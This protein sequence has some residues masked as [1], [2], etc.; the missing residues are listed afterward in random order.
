[1]ASDPFDSV[2]SIVSS[3]PFESVSIKATEKFGDWRDTVKPI[4]FGGKQTVVRPQDDAIWNQD[5]KRWESVTG[6]KMPDAPQSSPS[7]TA[8][9]INKANDY[10]G[11]ALLG[12][13]KAYNAMLGPIIKGGARL[14]GAGGIANGQED[15]EKSINDELALRAA[16]N[17]IG[18]T[19]A[20]IGGQAIPQS[21]MIAAIPGSGVLNNM[22]AG[23][24]T[25]AATTEGD[26][27]DRLS[28]AGI[29]AAGSGLLSG[30][31]KLV[32]SGAN[33]VVN[34][35]DKAKRI[36]NAT[37]AVV[38][39]GDVSSSPILQSIEQKLEWIPGTGMTAVRKKGAEAL[40][41]KVEGIRASAE[42][43]VGTK[44]QAGEFFDS[45]SRGLSERARALGK[46][47]EEIGQIV[48]SVPGSAGVDNAIKSVEVAA[49][50][51]QLPKTNRATISAL[52]DVLSD[53]DTIKQRGVT[54]GG[55]QSLKTEVGKAASEASAKGDTSKASALWDVYGGLK[56]DARASISKADASGKLSKYFDDSN[57]AW[58]KEFVPYSRSQKA[59]AESTKKYAELLVAP[60]KFQQTELDS[61]LKMKSSDVP[62]YINDVIDQPGRDALKSAILD[63]ISGVSSQGR[64][65]IS[66]AKLRNA[67]KSKEAWINSLF[68]KE[69]QAQ[70]K[71]LANASE[72]MDRFGQYMERLGTGKEIEKMSWVKSAI[73]GLASVGAGQ[74]TGA[75]VVAI[76][77]TTV[78]LG[79]AYTALTATRAGQDFLRKAAIAVPGSKFM[80][81]IITKELPVALASIQG[82]KSPESDGA[83]DREK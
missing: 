57:S 54:F 49:S 11:D 78:G 34:L 20:S 24:L 5:S 23:A 56:D 71:G 72:H 77:G 67:I 65:P 47:F 9:I 76:H 12:T 1:M 75:P 69:E 55:I 45:A 25:A 50:R 14:V 33:K 70:M 30:G 38:P 64:T 40:S 26:A 82:Q 48:D 21:L 43:I 79:R 46:P 16:E 59:G 19:I 39:L 35:I 60:Q 17:P 6:K 4:S 83:I 36:Y 51:V 28:S 15:Y 8:K 22:K 61:L 7:T 62:K 10:A 68:S 31:A 41:S 27:G 18:S 81:S 3:D 13:G 53:L 2:S 29:A 63:D 58:E 37:G 73:G 42:G 66:P 32:K 44:G 74:I 52:D 80:D